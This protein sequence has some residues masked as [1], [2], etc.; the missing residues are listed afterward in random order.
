MRERV[1]QLDGEFLITS[2]GGIGT[3]VQVVL[4]LSDKEGSQ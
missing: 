3:T 2:S 1:R 4:P